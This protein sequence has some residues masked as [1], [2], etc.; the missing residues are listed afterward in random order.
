MRGKYFNI[1]TF[2]FVNFVLATALFILQSLTHAATQEVDKQV[3]KAVLTEDW[4]KVAKLLDSVNPETP[5]P[6]LRMI[7]GHADLA[8]NRNNESLC[9]FLSALSEKDLEKWEDWSQEFVKKNPKKVVAHYFMGDALARFEKLDDALIAFNKGLELHA[10]HTLVLNARGVTYATKGK[11]AN[12]RVDFDEATKQA[13]FPLSDAYANIGALRIQKKNGA[14]GAI[15]AFNNALE[16]TPNFALAYHGR[17]CVNMVLNRI[18][19]AK[20]DLDRANKESTCAYRLISGNAVRYVSYWSGMKQKEFLAMNSGK[21]V[22]STFNVHYE[23]VVKAWDDFKSHAG[24]PILGQH[25]YNNF[26]SNLAQLPFDQKETF[27]KE[28]VMPELNQNQNL[29]T[30][31]DHGFTKYS[32][33]H[34]PGGGADVFTDQLDMYGGI[35]ASVGFAHADPLVTGVGAGM[36][37]T[38]TQLDGWNTIHKNNIND[39]NNLHIDYNL[40]TNVGGVDTNMAEINWEEEGDW[41]FIEFYGLLYGIKSEEMLLIS[42]G[43]AQNE[44]VK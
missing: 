23:E 26:V 15:R 29:K 35:T 22:G 28:L 33:H 36:V 5:S 1:P 27:M 32:Q 41:P 12:A 14:E 24:Q 43:G 20:K 40:S 25:S 8:L 21:K 19:G 13:S 30:N 34:K 31:Y 42:S 3:E 7:K 38:S 6:V 9:L 16:I 11:L 17:G 18:D 10:N 39:M 4:G 2:V 44:D 37:I